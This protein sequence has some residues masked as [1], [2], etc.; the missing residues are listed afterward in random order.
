LQGSVTR[1]DQSAQAIVLQ[2]MP[3]KLNKTSYFKVKQ[4]VIGISINA[5]LKPLYRNL[6]MA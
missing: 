2:A 6:W 1:L 4:D 5:A 3:D